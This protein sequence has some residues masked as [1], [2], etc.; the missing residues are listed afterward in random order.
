MDEAVGVLSNRIEASVDR[1]R[2][3]L[4]ALA[5]GLSALLLGA[6]PLVRPFFRLDVFAPEATLAAAS[7]AVASA[8]WLIAHLMGMGGFVLL[9]GAIP[10]LYVRL[11]ADGDGPRLFRATVLGIA[12]IALVLPMF[13]VETYAV[14]AIGQIYLGG[15][16]GIAPIVT[17]IYRG[18]GT[19]VMLLGLLLLAIGALTFANAIWRRGDVAAVG[20]SHVGGGPR[21]LA[22]PAPAVD[23]RG[24]WAADRG[25]GSLARGHH[26]APGPIGKSPGRRQLAVARADESAARGARPTSWPAW[27]PWRASPPWPACR[28]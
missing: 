6:F 24:R 10:A 21:R 28:D 11:A 22:A 25:G 17:L 2:A 5:L 15:Q 13:G 14:P 16:P 1:T 18:L 27:S 12:G 20:R 19:A 8:P 4:G 23:P 9:L 3:R 26:V 7:P